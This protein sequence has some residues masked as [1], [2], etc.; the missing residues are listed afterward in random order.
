M[1]ERKVK[2]GEI[3]YREGDDAD[4][5]HF[6]SAGEVEVRRM[7]G[8]EDVL[9]AVLK[10]GQIFGE[11]GV[12]QGKQRRTTTTAL[13][14]V[15]LVSVAKDD[16][17]KA[18]GATDSFALPVLRML[19]ERLRKVEG[20]VTDH[21]NPAR[22]MALDVARIVL[23]PD[24]PEMEK[25]IGSDGIEVGHLP[26]IV[27]RSNNGDEAPKVSDALLRI[28]PGDRFRLELEHFAIEKHDGQIF[29]RDLGSHLGTVVNSHRIASFEEHWLAA[30]DIGANRV[31]AGGV[32]SPYSFCVVLE[33]A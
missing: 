32:E 13:S 7:A 14:D 18:F 31:Q 2:T 16:F 3:I 22:A 15:T 5:V 29:V 9:L 8:E 1:R 12:V 30:L 21:I 26:Y 24:S 27:G 20:L 23:L 28:I 17:L 25:Q 33:K 4:A 11:I 6:I 10:D 19:C